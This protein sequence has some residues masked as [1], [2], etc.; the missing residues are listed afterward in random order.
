[1]IYGLLVSSAHYNNYYCYADM[2]PQFEFFVADKVLLTGSIHVTNSG[3]RGPVRSGPVHFGF[4]EDT[5]GA[6]CSPKK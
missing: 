5:A 6:L 1:M 4:A 2:I 3:G